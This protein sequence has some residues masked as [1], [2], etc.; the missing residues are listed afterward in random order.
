VLA[1]FIFSHQPSWIDK[2]MRVRD[3][4]VACF[5]L[6]TG[7]QLATL[8]TDAKAGRVG[9]FKV[10]STSATEIVVGEDDKHSISGYQFSARAAR[11]LTAAAS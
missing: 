6:K 1:R 10:Y 3:L 9:I 8:A 2:L 7:G 11:R 5:G 4:I